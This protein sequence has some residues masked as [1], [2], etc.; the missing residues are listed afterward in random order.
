M[1]QMPLS[2][3]Q[4]RARQGAASAATVTIVGGMLVVGGQ[5]VTA[6]TF[7]VT[8]LLDDGSGGTLR[9]QIEAANAAPGA[10]TIT[11]DSSLSGG[12]ITLT[13]V[14]GVND[15]LSIVGLGQSE[16]TLRT[17]IGDVLYLY[18]GAAVTLSEVTISDAE[19]EGIVAEASGDLSLSSVTVSGAGSNGL[20]FDSPGADLS[21]VD[22][23]ID[24]NGTN[25][26]FVDAANYVE[27]SASSLSDNA[28]AG[29]A[30]D[31]TLTGLMIDGSSFD[32]NGQM[33]LSS[34]L[35]DRTTRITGST[36]DN[37]VGA[38]VYMNRLIDGLEVADSSFSGNGFAGLAMSYVYGAGLTI[39]GATVSNNSG[40]GLRNLMTIEGDA[41]VTAST[42]SDNAGR[43]LALYDVDRDAVIDGV[44][45][46]GNGGNGISVRG[47]TGDLVVSGSTVSDT[48]SDGVATFYVAGEVSIVQ[49]TISGS[50][51]SAIRASE[52]GAVSVESST[53]TGNG[54][55][56]S[57]P[58]IDASRVGELAVEHSTITGNG[59]P[60]MTE[61][62]VAA[63]DSTVTV[64]HSVLTD[65]GGGPT[66]GVAGTGTFTV[67]HSLLPEGTGLGGT[68][69]E[70]N[71]PQLG[72]LADNGG[73]TE[74]MLPQIGSPVINAGDPAFAAPPTVDQRGV[75]R[76]A[77]ER[78]DIGAVE[79]Q[80][81]AAVSPLA[82]ERFVDT[83]AAGDTA[84]GLFEAEGAL[85]AQ[86]EYRVQIA[87]RGG[88][89]V[90]AKAAV[91]NVTAVGAVSGGFLTVHPCEGEPPNA[92][93]LNFVPGVN[94][95][96]EL[97]APLSATG[98][99][100][101]FTSAE[102]HVLVDA[103]GYVDAASP[104]VPVSP[105]R[106]LD[107]R[108]NGETFD[109]MSEA[110]GRKAAGSEEVVMVAGRGAV[111]ADAAAVIVNVT[112]VS[113]DG[114]GFVTVHACED[115]P[116]NA[117][118]LNYVEGINRANELV[119]SVNAAGEI[120]LFTSEAADLLVDV[121]GYIP[122]GAGFTA[123][124]PS[125]FMDTRDT[126]ETIDDVAEAEGKL[127]PGEAYELQVTGRGGV[128]VDASAVVINVTAAA[129]EDVGF[130]TV[131][132]CVDPLPNASSLNFVEGVNGANELIALLDA[133]G[134]VCVYTSASTHL[135][136]DVV[137]YID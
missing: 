6:A 9:E 42:F 113:P 75:P 130:V 86:S 127:G 63:D 84:D 7:E 49:S 126:G 5:P 72:A 96:N 58:V 32:D 76:V 132:P 108:A 105:A 39:D 128:P 73:S 81:V 64:D 25:G 70:S 60:G 120:C 20:R 34:D 22:S 27:V 97:I 123:M 74:T 8:S 115:E 78:I 107:T 56:A 106:Y 82:P 51:G 112:A 26:I 48:D 67:S 83:R 121:V 109:G 21:I 90:G 31:A 11:F 24:G 35:V 43:G 91:I 38:G 45:A 19:S 69:V 103:V 62:V 133:D 2:N 116:P 94:V 54:G 117:S 15:D 53:L 18:N 3:G 80:P 100:C 57:D 99:V 98:E 119:A 68:T 55:V 30:L 122:S 111:P 23:M 17:I 47:V 50:D 129:A 52:V 33:G 93:S 131:H 87:G 77:D 134:K 104:L 14:I 4:V 79:V 37:N 66:F 40:D 28:S 29:A 85:A 137:A 95:A 10:D 136:V 36:F 44:T 41:S 114:V 92:S 71:D 135:L 125:R 118:S 46:S 110:V 1:G 61:A 124:V 59:V 13:G 101:I 65:N 88:V 89:P 16:L 102:V 12:T